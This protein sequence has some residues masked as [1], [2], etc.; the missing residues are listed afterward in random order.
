MTALFSAASTA[1]AG[2]S[3]RDIPLYGGGF[4]PGIIYRQQQPGRLYLRTNVGGAF[5]WNPVTA[6]WIPLSD[7]FGPDK[8][9]WPY[10]LSMATDP[11]DADRVYAAVGGYAQSWGANG[12]ILISTNRGDTWAEV[13][14]PFKIGGNDSGEYC[15]EHLQVDPNLPSILFMAGWPAGLWKSDDS[16]ATWNP[17]PSLSA[18]NLNFMCIDP[19][20]GT[21]GSASQRMIVGSMDT[22][23]N[24]WITANAGATWAPIANQPATYYPMHAALSGNFLFISYA[25]VSGL[26]PQ[27]A[28]IGSVYRHDLSSGA[29]S[30]VT[31]ANGTF[32]FGGHCVDK[33]NPGTVLA[34]TMCRW[35]P[36]EEVYCS[37]NNG[38]SWKGI[39][40]NGIIDSSPAPYTRDI[41]QPCWISDIQIN[42]FNSNEAVFVTGYGIYMTENLT[43]AN[44]EKPVTWV[45]RDKGMEETVVLDLAS[46]PTGPWLYSVMADVNGFRY[47]T[48]DRTPTNG[49]FHPVFPTSSSIDFAALNPQV[50]VRTHTRQYNGDP[51]GPRGSYSLDGGVYGFYRSDDTAAT[52]QRINDDQHQFGVVNCLAGDPKLYGRVYVG[53]SGRGTVYGDLESPRQPQLHSSNNDTA[54]WSLD[55]LSETG[56]DYILQQAPHLLPQTL[57]QDLSTNPGTGSGLA[58]NPSS[59]LPSPE[60]WFRIRVQLPR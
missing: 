20:S 43:D 55:F 34:G 15:G 42:P 41:F 25:N 27:P 3:W 35:W 51:S 40:L 45:F 54:Q 26:N 7:A 17:V 52:W 31:P 12:A 8:M 33:Q 11:V 29:W 21:P 60:Q 23:N 32:G 13:P 56:F 1:K 9:F 47:D 53:T 38:A 48:L 50:V 16:G 5:R 49:A 57:W 22:T 6:Q 2:Y 30:N 18:T 59:A 37:T 39:V 4:S 24:L 58:L 14:V 19:A 44:A 36:G 28:T 46:P 10:V